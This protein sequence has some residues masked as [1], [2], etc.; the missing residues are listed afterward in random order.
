MVVR[1][2]V[3]RLLYALPHSRTLRELARNA[4]VS[5]TAV[6][7]VVKEL[8][9]EGEFRVVTD[10][11][12]YNLTRIVAFVDTVPERLPF[13]TTGVRLF[14]SLE[15]K[16]VL[17]MAYIPRPLAEDYIKSLSEEAHVLDW[18]AST[19][20]V[21]WLPHPELESVTPRDFDSLVDRAHELIPLRTNLRP[22]ATMDQIDLVLLWGKL[23]LGPFARP[24]EIFNRL[25][26]EGERVEAPSKQVLS[27]HYRVHIQPGWRYNTYF[28]YTSQEELPFTAYYMKGKEAEKVARALALLPTHGLAIIGQGRALYLGQPLCAYH[29]LLVEIPQTYVVEPLT[30]YMKLDLYTDVPRLWKLLDPETKRWRWVE[31]KIPVKAQSQ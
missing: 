30:M 20:Y 29:P 3:K 12:F 10:D 8:S 11:N 15:G 18:F 31:E 25:L 9:K 24:T 4:K 19:D 5:H 2:D 21:A 13:G 23:L 28:K 27:Y 6:R 1:I 22:L 16:K 14:N 26:A 7:R 17:V